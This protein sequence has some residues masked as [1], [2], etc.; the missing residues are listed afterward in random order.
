MNVQTSNAGVYIAEALPVGTYR[1]GVEAQGFQSAVQSGLVL[2]VADRLAVNF[3]L[4]VGQVTQRLEV[5]ATAQ[6]VETESGE[7]SSRAAFQQPPDLFRQAR[8]LEQ[9]GD[10]V[11]AEQ[12]YSR[13]LRQSPD[14]AEGHANLGVVEAHLNKLDDAIREYHRA[15][16]L[17]PT[18]RGIYLNLGIAYFR[19]NDFWRAVEPLRKFLSFEP[20][21]SQA[22]RLLGLSY[23]ELDRY[24]EAIS[25]LV[26]HRKEQDP[27]VLFAL[28]ACYARSG[29]T[30][31]A[32]QVLE[33]LLTSEPD[34]TRT[35]YLTGL[36]HVGLN[37]FPQALQEFERLYALD[38]N[39]P[40]VNFYL[41]VLQARLGKYDEGEKHLREEMRRDPRSFPA[42][43]SLGAL[44][45]KEGR[46][47]E[48]VKFL[49]QARAL[50]PRHSDTLYELGRAYQKTGGLDKAWEDARAATQADPKNRPAHYLLAQIARQRGDEQ[51]AQ[52]EF[53][54]AQSLS[55]AK[56]ESDILR[57]SE[58]GRENK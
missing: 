43:F 39:W 11:G 31:E 26:P 47:E 4:K 18:L 48:A 20:K 27:T 8:Q 51:T 10:L 6:L 24:P 28:A 45:S 36:V 56:A 58:P 52:R 16:V 13:Y 49:E 37:Q 34:S 35:H 42:F 19:K 29:K 53:H 57:L 54:I 44:L 23:A 17:Q 22:E 2:N 5:T 21:N 15:L 50:N 40:Q 14:S 25:L 1:V 55:D 7:Q 3:T 41:G 9:R 38:P 46:Y 30:Q 32:R 33:S 12:L